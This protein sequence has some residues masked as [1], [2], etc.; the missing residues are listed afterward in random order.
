MHSQTGSSGET[1]LS[2]ALFTCLLSANHP[3][4]LSAP[5]PACSE[6]GGQGVCGMDGHCHACVNFRYE[7]NQVKALLDKYKNDPWL[8]FGLS[9][10]QYNSLDALSAFVKLSSTFVYSI[11][12]HL[13]LIDTTGALVSLKYRILVEDAYVGPSPNQSERNFLPSCPAAVQDFQGWAQTV[14]QELIRRLDILLNAASVHMRTR[15]SRRPS[16]WISNTTMSQSRI[17]PQAA[18]CLSRLM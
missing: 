5:S 12:T 3:P 14:V 2:D 17:R 8:E 15:S 16:S 7:V 11:Y 18:L 13:A 6:Y 9:L 10:K 4:T 1:I